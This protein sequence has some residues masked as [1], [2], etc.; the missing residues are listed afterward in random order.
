M[1]TF[2][3]ESRIRMMPPKTLRTVSALQWKDIIPSS[4]YSGLLLAN[5][6]LLHTVPPDG[7]TTTM[8]KIHLLKIDI[9]DSQ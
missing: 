3:L 1:I 5:K 6:M 9:V 2:G 4:E 8:L 7:S